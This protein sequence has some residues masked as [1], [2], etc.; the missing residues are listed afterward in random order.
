[1]SED[2]TEDAWAPF[3]DEDRLRAEDDLR[4]RMFALDMAVTVLP[5]ITSMADSEDTKFRTLRRAS[6]EF[7]KILRGQTGS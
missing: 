5:T 4:I 1:M 6:V 3:P 2:L 7:E